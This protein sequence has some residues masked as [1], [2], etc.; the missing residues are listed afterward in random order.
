MPTR[1][2]SGDIVFAAGSNNLLVAIDLRSGQRIWEREIGSGNQPWLAGKYLFLLA[3]D[4][5]L[6]AIQADSGKIVWDTKIPAGN[7]VS[8]QVGVTYAGP[9]LINNRLLVNTSNGYTFYVSPYT[10]KILGYI[11]NGDGSSLPPVAAGSQVIIT[12]VDADIIA[13]Q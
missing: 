2:I 10:G 3:N 1:V 6:M 8:D 4:A 7:D 12:T 11:E 13:Y 5:R 9:L